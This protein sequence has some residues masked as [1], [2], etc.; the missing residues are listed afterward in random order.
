MCT[1]AALEHLVLLCV[2][3]SDAALN[4]VTI[5]YPPG[6]HSPLY[7]VTGLLLFC[8]LLVSID[9]PVY[10]IWT[11]EDGSFHPCLSLDDPTGFCTCEHMSTHSSTSQQRQAL[12]SSQIISTPGFS[13][14]VEP[15]ITLL[16][17]SHKCVKRIIYINITWDLKKMSGCIF[18]REEI[19]KQ[20]G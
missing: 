2:P 18:V 19:W 20:M 15:Y 10:C 9:I 3:L 6:S 16:S 14:S 8:C 5:S 11:S 12:G 7:L 17:E 4:T 1:S 13:C